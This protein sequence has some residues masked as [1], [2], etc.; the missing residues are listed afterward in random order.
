MPEK[1]AMILDRAELQKE[2]DSKVRNP[3]LNFL[4]KRTKKQETDGKR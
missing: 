2:G 1:S 3:P 4:E